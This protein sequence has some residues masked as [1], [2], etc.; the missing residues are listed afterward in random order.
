MNGHS[1]LA[2]KNSLSSLHSCCSSIVTG[3]TL[4]SCSNPLFLNFPTPQRN[5]ICPAPPKL[6][7][8]AAS[9]SQPEGLLE[10]DNVYISELLLRR[11]IDIT[12]D[13]FFRRFQA[14]FSLAVR[15]PSHS[16]CGCTQTSDICSDSP[17]ISA[18]S[19]TGPNVNTNVSR[20]SFDQRCAYVWS[21]FSQGR[22]DICP[23]L[24]LNI[25]SI[26]G[27][28]TL[29]FDSM[30]GSELQC[31]DSSTPLGSYSVDGLASDVLKVY[32][33]RHSI[34]TCISVVSVACLYSSLCGCV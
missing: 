22:G 26:D 33:L 29:N 23:I 6:S 4:R 24:W 14:G 12:P 2:L 32:R 3:N 19:T 15:E 7:Y 20:Y 13:V 34:C 28:S 9:V 30:A 18:L 8:S 25:T 5:E 11:A 17:Y 21:L 16:V 1:S 31:N 27:C 10:T